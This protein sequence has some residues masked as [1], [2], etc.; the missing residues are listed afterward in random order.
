VERLPDQHGRQ[1]QAPQGREVL[2]G[3]HH[4][5]RRAELQGAQDDPL[6]VQSLLQGS[7]GGESSQASD[8]HPE[9][10]AVPPSD[11]HPRVHVRR[12][13]QRCSGP[14]A[15]LPED[16]RE[17]EGQ[18]SRRGPAKRQERIRGEKSE[19]KWKFCKQY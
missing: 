17:A 14:A 19:V 8:H 18:R 10:R 9:G 13:S 15:S 4:R 12:R 5:L 16:C 3:R 11:R 2:H 6:R 7:A 1:L